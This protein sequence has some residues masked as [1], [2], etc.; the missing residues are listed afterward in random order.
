MNQKIV[1][2][3]TPEMKLRLAVA[4]LWEDGESMIT[5]SQEKK[6]LKEFCL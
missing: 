5:E 2:I 6:F 1:L 3:L 4:I